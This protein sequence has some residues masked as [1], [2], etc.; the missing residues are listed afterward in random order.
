MSRRDRLG[1]GLGALFGEYLG[2]DPREFSEGEPRSV[3]ISA[4]VPNPFQPRRE[5]DEEE[6]SELSASIAENGLLQPLVVR[7]SPEGSGENW[8][9]VAGERRWR[10]VQRL[11]WK[12]VPVLVRPL[13]DR[14]MLVVALVENLQRSELSPLEEAVGYQRLMEEFGLSQ[15][16][17]AEAVGKNRSTVANALRL[18]QLPASVRRLL[19]EGR[20]TAGHAR[21]LLG[22][23]NDQRISELA[24]RVVSEGWNVRQVEAEVSKERPT[25][26]RRPGRPRPREAAER[27]L[28]EE[29]ERALGTSVKIRHGRGMKGR[30]EI[31]FYG[32]EDFERIYEILVGA[33]TSE[34]V[35]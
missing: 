7:P 14:A 33:P 19:N 27:R 32:A 6:L 34:V 16:E 15:R 10:A 12:E 9:L 13:D 1:K 24:K 31:S 29:L 21:A 5:F 18:L 3:E 11:G 35:S 4:I 28:E 22:L 20:L 23:G 30:V 17:V 25:R 8:E 2:G 26:E